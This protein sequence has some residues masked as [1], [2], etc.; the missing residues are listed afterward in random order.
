MLQSW[1][2]S[3]IAPRE[4]DGDG[5]APCSESSRTTGR[6]P[7]WSQLR[8]ISAHSMLQQNDRPHRAPLLLWCSGCGLLP[9][10]WSSYCRSM[11]SDVHSQ[12]HHNTTLRP[13]LCTHGPQF[14]IS[15]FLAS[16]LLVLGSHS[17]LGTSPV[18]KGGCSFP[19]LV[20]IE[21]RPTTTP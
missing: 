8:P 19:C 10:P 14:L 3:A 4:N 18:I 2:R 6:P 17:A 11:A 12:F 20:P 5:V 7:Q 13:R 15:W 1:S 16:A 21:P 9:W